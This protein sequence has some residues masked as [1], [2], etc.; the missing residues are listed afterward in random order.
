MPRAVRRRHGRAQFAHA[1]LVDAVDTINELGVT[2]GR[3]GPPREV[4]E[5]QV[6]SLTSLARAVSGMGPSPREE[7]PAGAY[8]ALCQTS[9]YAGERA[10]LAPLDL[11]KVSLHSRGC[12]VSDLASLLGRE[13]AREVTRSCLEEVRDQETAEGYLA[14]EGP[15]RAYSD[16]V[17]RRRRKT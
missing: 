15:V 14:T 13:G 17:L 2:T 6:A 12:G 7:T 5:A 16:P 9:A 11:D 4:S 3:A 8:R 10:D 1:L